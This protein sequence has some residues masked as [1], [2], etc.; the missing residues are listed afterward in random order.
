MQCVGHTTGIAQVLS[1]PDSIQ[2]DHICHSVAP[3]I[4]YAASRYSSNDV[5]LRK[6]GGDNRRKFG[7]LCKVLEQSNDAVL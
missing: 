5:N 2:L 3:I 1:D 7:E 6:R 4:P